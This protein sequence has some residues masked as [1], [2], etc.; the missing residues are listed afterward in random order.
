[1][2]MHS[3]GLTKLM[4]ECGELVQIAAKKSAYI[5]ADNHP[6]SSI[7]MSKRLED[8]MGDV[9]A[10]IDFVMKKLDLNPVSIRQRRASK[11]ETFCAWDKED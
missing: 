2:A 1:M 6:D 4:E 3:K 7:P 10:A 8:E 11:Y 5:H 9:L